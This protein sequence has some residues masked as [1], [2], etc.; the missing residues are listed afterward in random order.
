MM[1]VSVSS[2]RHWITADA[3]RSSAVRIPANPRIVTATSA[4]LPGEN[5]KPPAPTRGRH[6]ASVTM[7]ASVA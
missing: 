2:G 6:T 1:Q 3:I 7:R 4:A 5:L